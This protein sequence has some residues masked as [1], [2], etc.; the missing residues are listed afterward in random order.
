MQLKKIQMSNVMLDE[1]KKNYI[2]ELP[3]D[4]LQGISSYLKTQ[5][6]SQFV[7]TCRLFNKSA[8]LQIRKLKFIYHVLK[9]DLEETA[10]LINLYP[11][12]L[13]EKFSNVAPFMHSLPNMTALQYVFWSRDLKMLE[14]LYSRFSQYNYLD[15]AVQQLD[16]HQQHVGDGAH[17]NFQPLIIA[18]NAFFRYYRSM[19]QHLPDDEFEDQM[20]GELV[21]LAKTI[22]RIQHTLPLHV[23]RDVYNPNEVVYKH[24][25]KFLILSISNPHCYGLQDSQLPTA[26]A[27]APDLA[28]IMQFQTLTNTEIEKF[29]TRIFDTVNTNKINI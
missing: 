7:L 23:I 25:Y 17:Y 15:C 10:N 16:E 18:Y 13:L 1:N 11:K 19:E 22:S 9:S 6:L 8:N 5:E 29:K 14:L 27:L 21:R 28:A 3:Y 4:L 2:N 12:L 26:S 20:Y 24:G